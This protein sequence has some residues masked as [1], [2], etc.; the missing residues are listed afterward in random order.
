MNTREAIAWFKRTFGSRIVSGVRGTPF[1]IDLVCAIAN[2][3]TGYIWSPLVAKGLSESDVLRL[4]VGDTLDADKGRSV[5]PRTKADLLSAPHGAQMFQIAREACVEMAR[6][7]PGYGFVMNNPNKFCHG[8]GIFQ[9]DIQFFRNNPDFFLEKRWQDFSACLAQLLTELK[10]ALARQHWT[11]KTK[12]S[13]DEQV[14]VAIAYN[15]GSANPR[16]GF[17]QGHKSDDGRYYGENINEYMGIAQGIAL[18]GAV[19]AVVT[20]PPVPAPPAPT[21]VVTSFKKIGAAFEVNVPHT[22]LRLR[23]EPVIPAGDENANVIAR[24]PDGLVVQRLSPKKVGQFMHVEV[25][26]DGKY[27]TGWVS[28][29]CL[30]RVE[31]AKPISTTRRYVPGESG[32][33][34]RPRRGHLWCELPESRCREG[35]EKLCPPRGEKQLRE[36]APRQRQKRVR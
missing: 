24:L 14:F 35:E 30:V 23:S 20:A 13:Y 7:T 8:F 21:P 1:S 18:D 27:L 36:S 5:F 29:T 6:V 2:Q 34:G 31:R 4:C 10:E 17:K 12:L 28:A 25:I 11:D 19:P 32:R 3:E 15:R 26:L 16:F 22:D 9:Y 33:W